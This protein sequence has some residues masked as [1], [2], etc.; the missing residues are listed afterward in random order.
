MNESTRQKTIAVLISGGGTTLKNLIDWAGQGRLVPKIAC[1]ISSRF[2]A[3]GLD[4][5]R[6]ADM[7][8]HV[9]DWNSS[10]DISKLNC[11]LFEIL[12]AY[13]VDLVVAGGFLKRL[14]IPASYQ[15]RVVNIHPSLIPSFCGYGFYGLKVHAAVLDFGC[16]VSGC[17][18]HFV[19]DEFDHGPIIAQGSVPVL[20]DDSPASLAARVFALECQIYPQ[21]IN[22]LL[23]HNYRVI[24]R[25]VLFDAPPF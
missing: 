3:K 14:I 13:A 7:P 8:S 20:D 23:T 2:D 11:Q 21:T 16:K 25:R 9:V 19:D 17:T 24:G 22:R 18:V 4:Y 15:Q 12:D 6:E 1:V 10:R 5:A